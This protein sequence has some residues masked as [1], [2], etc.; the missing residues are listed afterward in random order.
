MVALS[1]RL[2]N[3]HAVCTD[4]NSWFHDSQLHAILFVTLKTYDSSLMTSG[5]VLPGLR[6]FCTLLI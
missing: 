6:E 1:Q 2:F 3:E 4:K 5:V